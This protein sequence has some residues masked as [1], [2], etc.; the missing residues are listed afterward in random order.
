MYWYYIICVI[1]FNH[2]LIRYAQRIYRNIL[3]SEYTKKYFFLLR[4]K[5]IIFAFCFLE[6]F[7]KGSL[8][9]RQNLEYNLLDILTVIPFDLLI[10]NNYQRTPMIIIVQIKKTTSEDVQLNI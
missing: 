1:I 6:N 3:A 2:I 4:V 9:N 10:N 8:F 5:L 7:L